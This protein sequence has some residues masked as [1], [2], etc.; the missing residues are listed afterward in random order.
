[1]WLPLL[2]LLAHLRDFVVVA[3]AGNDSWALPEPKPP[4]IPASYPW[5]IAVQASGVCGSR[6]CFSNSGTVA[7]PGCGLISLVTPPPPA[8]TGYDYFSGTSG[9]APQVSGLAARYVQANVADVY[10]EIDSNAAQS[11]N[12]VIRFR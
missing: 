2:L 8:S 9:S 12:R 5:V 4:Q 10:K 7:A 11:P 1:M 3:S 6:A